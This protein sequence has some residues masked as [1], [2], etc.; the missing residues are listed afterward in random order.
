ML[1]ATETENKQQT[2][3]TLIDTK[4][5]KTE[6]NVEFLRGVYLSACHL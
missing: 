6:I 4:D 1:T 3:L 2:G 5:A